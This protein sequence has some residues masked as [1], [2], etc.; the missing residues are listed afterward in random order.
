MRAYLGLA[1]GLVLG[2]SSGDRRPR[3][4]AP[5][6]LPSPAPAPAASGPSLASVVFAARDTQ[7]LFAVAED[8]SQPLRLSREGARAAFAGVLPGRRVLYGVRAADASLASLESVGV[9]GTARQDL[10]ALPPGRFSRIAA[11]RHH[12]RALALELGRAAEPGKTDVVVVRAGQA[13]VVVAEDAS[14]AAL[15]GGRVAYGAGGT[16]ASAALDGSDVRTLG[17]GD[18]QDRL[19]EARGGR[20]LVT[21]HANGLGDVRIVKLDGSE[22]VDLGTPEADDRAFG[23]AGDTRA[24]LTH[25]TD[26]ARSVAVV[27]VDGS[28]E[29]SLAVGASPALV[30]AAGELLFGDDAGSLRAVAL[31]EGAGRLLDASAGKKLTGAREVGD[32][33]FFVGG[34]TG[35]ELRTARLDGH[36]A[37]ALCAQPGWQPFFG[38]VTAE[39]RAVFYRALAGQLEGGRL[40]SVKLDGTD[41]QPFG[42]TVQNPDGSPFTT[43]LADQDFEAVTPAG[44]VIFEAEFQ[45][46]EAHLLVG[47]P[48]DDGGQRARRLVDR[49]DLRFVALVE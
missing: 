6:P 33:V 29:R 5:A 47:T 18:G 34:M 11:L 48:G 39:G 1:L 36:G 21:L 42:E 40:F 4:E 12:R 44:R 31:A 25:G 38:G 32:R 46:T 15:A 10:G 14:L 8:G 7:E 9:D 24:I 2:C 43:P 23:F 16:L 26:A 3:D 30:T 28:S 41:L 20:L 19:V 22:R 45:E 13:P 37:V 27:G 49:D 35:L 17:A